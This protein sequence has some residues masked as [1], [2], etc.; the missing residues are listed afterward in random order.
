[1]LSRMR[2][3]LAGVAAALLALPAA[4]AAAETE[5]E[6]Q[7]YAEAAAGAAARYDALKRKGG[8]A[9]C[10]PDL[11]GTLRERAGKNIVYPLLYSPK[12]RMQGSVE[13]WNDIPAVGQL[14]F[15]N[16]S[17]AAL[18]PGL[19]AYF[20]A[21]VSDDTLYV[22][23]VA[24]DS[25]VNFGFRPAYNSDCFELF[26]DPFFTRD[27]RSDDS[28]MQ[29]FITAAD[30]A[31]KT[32][33]SEG[34]IPA[35]ARPVPVEGGWGVEI[36]IPLDNAYF[37]LK[38]FDGLAFGFN[39]SYNNNDDGK[40]RNQKITWSG[41]DRNDSSWN[42]PSVFGVMEVVR[43]DAQ[44][45]EPVRPGPAI[46]ENRRRRSA[47]ETFE[48]L[49]ALARSRPSPAVV[50]GFMSGR[51]DN[52][53]AFH[54]MAND[55][56]ANAVRLQLHG[57]GPKPTWTPENYPVFLDRLEEAVK[58]GEGRRNQSHPVAFEVPCELGGR[59]MWE[60]P[61]VEEGFKRYWRGI[62]ER[63]KPYA[64]TIWGYDLYNEPLGRS[65]LPYAPVEWR[66]MAVNIMKAIREV[67]KDV[68]IIYE[69]GPGGGW[70]G[71]ED[72]KP[73]PDS[74]V[75]YSL[76]FYEPGA[77]M[78]QGIAATQLQDPGLLA[79][80][81][82]STGRRISGLH[83]RNPVRRGVSGKI[84][85]AGHRVPGEIQGADLCRRIQRDR[86]GA[87][88]L[89]R[90]L[91]PGRDRHLQPPRLE[92]D[93]PRLPRISGLE[94][95]TRGRRGPQGCGAEAGQGER[96]RQSHEGGLQGSGR[97]QIACVKGK[98]E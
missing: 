35:E 30:P 73:L 41:L 65:Q 32:F 67:D 86:L 80:A 75:I 63:L 77:F 24:K 37:R 5:K 9:K 48:D 95:R 94:P 87:G 25:H 40:A 61:G 29:L 83:R 1:M 85:A 91:S 57:I 3:I 58:Q 13:S 53:R 31:G 6:L 46:E 89:R 59:E 49:G 12:K 90:P 98:E 72:L 36:A 19:E 20:K 66:Q 51:L 8:E 93:L 81:Q 16:T 68:W 18:P 71:F 82:E 26:L 97:Q 23:A 96:P 14:S 43:T 10:G 4:N 69:T 52:G 56:G 39:L 92:L 47:G 84:A 76:H 45:V 60:V 33:R 11:I 55:W 54:D 70:R 7:P 42:N 27:T 79:R 21:A 64:G 17:H 88:R 62:A 74:R 34:K 22:L 15:L 44:P 38:P 50:R 28:S 78:H 2:R